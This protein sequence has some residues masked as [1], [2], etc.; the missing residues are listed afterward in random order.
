[1][2]HSTVASV[3][4]RSAQIYERSRRQLVPC[5]D[6]F[7]ATVLELLPFDAAAAVR[8]LDLGA[9]TG[10]LSF[11]IA[12]RFPG[13]RLTLV[14]ISEPMLAQA[15]DRFAS[16]PERVECLVADYSSVPLPGP[17]DAVVSALSIHH[18]ADAQKAGLFA[19]VFASLV[20]GGRFV[21]ADQVLGPT[22]RLEQ[23]YQD[24]WLRQA[25]ERAVSAADLSAALERMREDRTAPLAD[26]LAWLRAAGFDDVDCFYKHYRF[27]VFGGRK[28][29]D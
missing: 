12:E 18:L 7:Y 29:L 17:F 6:D 2:G 10:L 15:R 8:V 23:H 5:F 4:D 25:R 16:T 27:A 11:F 21:N 3:F 13:A 28:P 24:T 19:R 1:M 26:Q 22:P 20:P 14:D 9:G